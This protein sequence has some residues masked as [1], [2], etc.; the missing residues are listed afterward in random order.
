MGE[1]HDCNEDY[2]HEMILL[3]FQHGGYHHGLG[4][5]GDRKSV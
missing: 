3:C 5:L 1:V 4:W 2:K